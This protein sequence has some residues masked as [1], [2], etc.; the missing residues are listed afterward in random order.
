MPTVNLKNK[1][2]SAKK[3]SNAKVKK[4]EERYTPTKSKFR[5]F[6]H[7]DSDGRYTPGV[8]N[9][10]FDIPLTTKKHLQYVVPAVE[11]AIESLKKKYIDVP[12]SKLL[13]RKPTATIKTNK[14]FNNK[15][16]HTLNDIAL[17]RLDQQV[18]NWRKKLKTENDTV[19]IWVPGNYYTGYKYGA[20]RAPLYKRLFDPR[21]QIETTLG[22][23]GVKATKNSIIIDDTYDFNQGQ[24]GNYSNNLYGTIRKWMGKHGPKD[25]EPDNE[26]IQTH[27]VFKRN[28]KR[29]IKN[30]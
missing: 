30:D 14:D 12:L 17:S 19:K 24:D 1:N 13:G 11:E 18:P 16:L 2:K 28:P 29:K 26:K 7:T 22:D 23:F 9:N 15:Y 25:T 20:S 10:L 4:P 5:L 21:G 6:S 8:L 27:I 3:T